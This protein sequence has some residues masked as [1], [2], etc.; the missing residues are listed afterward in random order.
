M[1]GDMV[2]VDEWAAIA[3]ALPEVTER[4]AWGMTCYR[5]RDKIFTSFDPERP[6]TVG[7]AVDRDERSVLISAEPGKFSMTNHDSVYHWVRVTLDAVGA[8]EMRELLEDAWRMKAPK[9]LVKAHD[10]AAAQRDE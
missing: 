8:G 4:P 5:V 7:V 2:S 3:E 1:L 6:E 9:R 10:E